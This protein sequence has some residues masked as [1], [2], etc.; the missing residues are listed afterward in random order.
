MYL[1]YSNLQE[2]RN[3]SKLYMTVR[4]HL[5]YIVLEVNVRNS[6]FYERKMFRPKYHWVKI[7]YLGAIQNR[8]GQLF[9]PI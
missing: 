6:I 2:R 5:L 7:K 4:G 1:D 8:H 9:L 3:I